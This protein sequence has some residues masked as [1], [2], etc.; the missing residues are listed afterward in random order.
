MRYIYILLILFIS[1]NYPG[2]GAIG[3]WSIFV[4]PVREQNMDKYLRSFY[5]EHPQ[6]QVP[7]EKKY[8]EDYWKKGGY[9]FLKDMFFYFNSNP[10]RVYYVTYIDAG[11]GVEN[12]DYARIALR[13]VYKEEDDRWYTKDKLSMEEQD[14]IKN[15]FRKEIILR[16]EQVT[17]T[18]AFIQD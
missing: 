16:L 14:N 1:C 15:V 9:G 18:K 2:E 17:K 12:P 13:A 3:G 10:A 4:F 11:F 5:Q 6:F 8:I 7:S